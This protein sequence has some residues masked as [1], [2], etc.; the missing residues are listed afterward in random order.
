VDR[1]R[2]RSGTTEGRAARTTSYAPSSRSDSS[3]PSIPTRTAKI[4]REHEM[5]SK[6]S[7]R[8][9][10]VWTGMPDTSESTS[11][12]FG[13]SSESEPLAPARGDETEYPMW[14]VVSAVGMG[15]RHRLVGLPRVAGMGTHDS[16][17]RWSAA[18]VM[19]RVRG[20]RPDDVLVHLLNLWQLGRPRT[21]RSGGPG[22]TARN[23]D[24][25]CARA[26]GV[27][28][29][30]KWRPPRRRC[31]TIWTLRGELLALQKQVRARVVRHAIGGLRKLDVQAETS[32]H[33]RPA[34][35]R[36][37]ESPNSV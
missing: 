32:G 12:R 4:L 6:V 26:W 7:R 1:R 20:R 14:Y 22:S 5:A 16:R 21:C 17:H 19:R 23:P 18:A 37:V 33:F 9:T 30:T 36:Y 27:S 35:V 10:G 24:R 3:T 8:F 2:A 31:T 25:R 28:V 34:C 11:G 15:G 29:S 13:S